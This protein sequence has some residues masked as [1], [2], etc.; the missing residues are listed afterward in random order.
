[1]VGEDPSRSDCRLLLER[2]GNDLFLFALM[3]PSSAALAAKVESALHCSALRVFISSC[4]PALRD[5]ENPDF[6]FASL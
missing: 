1:M 5:K 3:N 2:I 6:R 4:Y